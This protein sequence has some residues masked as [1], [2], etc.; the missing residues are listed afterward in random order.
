[1]LST[2]LRAFQRILICRVW[3]SS[4]SRGPSDVPYPNYTQIIP[5]F[6]RA[7]PTLGRSMLFSISKNATAVESDDHIPSS[8]SRAFQRTLVWLD[9]TSGSSLRAHNMPHPNLGIS[10][11]ESCTICTLHLPFL[12]S[13]MVAWNRSRSIHTLLLYQY[14]AE[15]N[16]RWLDEK[17]RSRSFPQCKFC[18]ERSNMCLAIIDSSRGTS[19]M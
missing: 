19:C 3:P 2:S 4:S 7:S 9:W 1:M 5:K 15:S 10:S 12:N 16:K 17:P 11:A 14:F 6:A 8:S 13:N 18:G